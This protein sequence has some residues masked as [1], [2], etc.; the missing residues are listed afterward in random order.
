M[1]AAAGSTAT[2]STTSGRVTADGVDDGWEVD[3]GM[4]AMGVKDRTLDDVEEDLRVDDGV[5]L[6]GGVGLLA[7]G[8]RLA[9]TRWRRSAIRSRTDTVQAERVVLSRDHGWC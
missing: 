6:T 4:A 5:T 8:V 2:G 9:M 3:A 7:P 1:R